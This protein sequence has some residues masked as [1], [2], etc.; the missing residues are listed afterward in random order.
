M[1]PIVTPKRRK[2]LSRWTKQCSVGKM[3]DMIEA[4]VIG[5]DS[6][7]RVLVAAHAPV[8]RGQR[9][10]ELRICQGIPLPVVDPAFDRAAGAH[11]DRDL[12]V[13]IVRNRQVPHQ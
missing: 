4:A 9:P 5:D 2:R 8:I 12:I 10:E 1:V 13:R 6:G 7:K 11:D 3:L